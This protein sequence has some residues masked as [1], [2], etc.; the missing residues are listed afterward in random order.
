MNVTTLPDLGGRYA[1]PPAAVSDFERDGHVLLRSVAATDEVAAYREVIRDVTLRHHD[2][3]TP[4]AERD[5]YGRAFRQVTNLWRQD[6]GV[7][8]FVLAPRFAGVAAQLLGVDAV[9][10]YHDQALFKEPGGG[11]TPWHQDAVYW[12]LDGRRCITM[13]MPLVDLDESMGSMSFASGSN[14]VGPL[15]DEIISDASQAHFDMVLGRG[16]FPIAD[17]M[18]RRLGAGDA[19]FHG[20]WTVHKAH[21]NTSDRMREVMTVIW[22]AD[23]LSARQPANEMQA[24]DLATWLPGVSPGAP[25]ASELN[26]LITLP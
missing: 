19:T 1:V 6:D 23:G 5:A 7:A 12:P 2:Q 8:R 4:L 14:N 26:P 11:P 3:L 21:P 22:F 18:P 9:R 16:D 10:I 24:R 13:W 20:G 15:G 25:A 17:P